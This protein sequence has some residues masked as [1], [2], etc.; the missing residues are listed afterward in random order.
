MQRVSSAAEK[1]QIYFAS[2]DGVIGVAMEEHVRQVFA[3]VGADKNALLILTLNTPGGLVDSM[4]EMV[5]AITGAPFPVVVWVAPSGA[6]SASA[7]AFLV[8]AAH[9][10]GHGSR[11]AY[12]CRAPR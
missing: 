11:Y 5:S 4:S 7:G 10:T 9:V 1:T 8:E 3:K 12:W 2:I 6:R